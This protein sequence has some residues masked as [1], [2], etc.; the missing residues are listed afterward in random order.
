M[1]TALAVF[2]VGQ[3]RTDLMPPSH[4]QVA[5]NVIALV[6]PPL[7]LVVWLVLQGLSGVLF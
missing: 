1:P 4:R 3:V 7:V 2:T 6:S 5:V